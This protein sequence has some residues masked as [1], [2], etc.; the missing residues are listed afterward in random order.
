MKTYLSTYVLL[1][2]L[3]IGCS[4]SDDA[5]NNG[6]EGKEQL[7]VDSDY[8]TLLTNGST[9]KT[10]LLNANAE[11][12]TLNPAA[13]SLTENAIPQLT[14]IRGSDFFQYHKDGDCGGKIIK[15]N[16]AS[17]KM[18]N[19]NLF[20]DLSDCMLTAKAIA[21]SDTSLFVAYELENEVMSNEYMVRII[22]LNSTELSF[23]DVPLNKQPV[24]LSLANNR[25]F[26]MTLDVEI[27]DENF[28]S[29]LDLN[30]NSLIHEKNI[31]FRARR[32]FTNMDDDI[33][34]SY[35]DLHTTLNSA[36]LSVVYT[37]YEEATAPKFTTNTADHFDSDG[38][39]YYPTISESVSIYPEIPAVYDFSK[40]L[41]TLYAYENFLTE[42]K[43]D[44]EFEIE[45]TT[46]INYDKN[47]DILIIGYKK[48]DKQ[49]GGLIRI[50]PGSE[51]AFIDN[52]D[53]DG[54]PYEIFVN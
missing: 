3:V 22:D 53:L 5:N 40:K 34:I 18:E 45:T 28:L 38:R 50:K 7:S 41:V 16:F 31:G 33:I 8:V 11:V 6:E 17:D 10:Q 29:V 46:A 37:N 47:N 30:T 9:L 51:P 26:I 43:R 14:A 2:L 21:F 44:F 24:G 49:K 35:D 13:S 12:I 32:I 39:L 20:D 27:S 25:L 36:N 52:I 54:V 4:K 1:A 42:A 48:L 15:H 23:I 19:I